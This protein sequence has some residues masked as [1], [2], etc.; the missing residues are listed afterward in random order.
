M[1][2]DCA[3]TILGLDGITMIV[4]RYYLLSTPYELIVATKVVATSTSVSNATEILNATIYLS[5]IPHK[6]TLILSLIKY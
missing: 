5:G 3:S 4:Y 2:I 1:L 6:Y